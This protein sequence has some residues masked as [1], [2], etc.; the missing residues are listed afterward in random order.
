M[1]NIEPFEISVEAMANISSGALPIVSG[2]FRLPAA[3][4]CVVKPN[5]LV[6]Y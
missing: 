1:P 5:D 3:L 2:I 4:I 6:E